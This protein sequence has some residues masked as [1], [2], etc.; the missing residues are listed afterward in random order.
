MLLDKLAH[1]RRRRRALR[2]RIDV[3]AAFSTWEETCVPSYLH[4]NR[5][6][7]G[8]AWARLFAAVELA[9]RHAPD[10]PVLDFGAAVGELVPLLPGRSSPYAFVEAEDHAAA[11]LLEQ[12]P[13]AVRRSLDELADGAYAAVFALD[14]LEHNTDFA[15]LL[16]RLS[17]ALRPDGVFVLS[18]PTENR[19]Y[20]LGRRIAG[21]DAHYHESDVHAIERAAATWLRCVDVKT[22][23]F[24]VPLF[25]VSVWRPR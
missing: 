25:R 21:F 15:S 10:G 18:G 12:H 4:R 17:R 11:L 20:A 19:L 13:F 5:L 16:E 3:A 9:E 23:P 2:S 6:A 24:G 8:V 14:A 22:V 7:A 1:V